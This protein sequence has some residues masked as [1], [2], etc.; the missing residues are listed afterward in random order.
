MRRLL[1]ICLLLP[2]GAARANDMQN[3]YDG[4]PKVPAKVAD[5]LDCRPLSDA[6]A[7]LHEREETASDVDQVD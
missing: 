7:A 3:I 2:G 1:V 4:L 5:E 6:S